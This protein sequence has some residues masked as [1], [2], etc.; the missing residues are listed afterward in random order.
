MKVQVICS[1]DKREELVQSLVEKGIEVVDSSDYVLLD[2]TYSD[3]KYIFAKD[4]QKNISLVAYEEILYFESFNKITEV[5]TGTGRLEVK[6]KLY[7][8]ETQLEHRD[9]VR[10]SKSVIVNILMIDKII[11]WIGSKF[12][13]D[14]K[15]GTQVEVTRTYYQTFKRHLGL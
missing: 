11:P 7:E 13:L 12:V 14:M 9:F 6:E 2:K 15:D 4:M 8:L 5:V 3:K 1:D 10:V